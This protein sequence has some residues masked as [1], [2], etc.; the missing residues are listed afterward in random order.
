[1]KK[2]LFIVFC[3]SCFGSVL[4]QSITPEVIASAGEHFTG[5]NAQLSWTIGEVVIE[6]VTDGNNFIT[7]GFHQPFGSEIGIEEDLPE[8][9]EVKIYPNPVREQLMITLQGND[10]PLNLRMFDMTGKL[11]NSRTI[12]ANTGSVILNVA[13]LANAAYLL[14]LVSDDKQYFA[15][16]KIQK[17]Y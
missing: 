13:G 12:A 11:V 10:M 15:T 2:I 8:G 17:T 9:M 14:Q 6:T 5:S 4:A 3:F 1:M 7:Q 16:Y